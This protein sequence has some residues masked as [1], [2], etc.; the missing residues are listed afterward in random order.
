M[1]SYL[2]QT[3]IDGSFEFILGRAIYG[4]WE[5]FRHGGFGWLGVCFPFL[6]CV[7]IGV[8]G[9]PQSRACQVSGFETEQARGYR[10]VGSCSTRIDGSEKRSLASRYEE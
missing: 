9:L 6:I 5:E 4:R 3:N 10:K 2:F 8:D 7:W 1:I